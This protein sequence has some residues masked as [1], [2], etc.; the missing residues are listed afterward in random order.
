[1]TGAA[2]VLAEA[3]ADPSLRDALAAALE[4]NRQLAE[5]TGKLREENARLREDNARLLARS[6]ERDAELDRVQADLAVLQRMLFGRGS[7]SRRRASA[8]NLSR[9]SGNSTERG[10]ELAKISQPL[11]V[12][13]ID[14]TRA[15]VPARHTRL[16][17]SDKRHLRGS[18]DEV[19]RAWFGQPCSR[20]WNRHATGA[21]TVAGPGARRRWT[22][23]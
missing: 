23:Q 12:H 6:A 15:T 19:R 8:R 2:A 13:E 14:K 16:H 1:M 11:G 21:A 18:V 5:L 4:A 22:S 9:E 3:G 10:D 7:R 20:T 17:V